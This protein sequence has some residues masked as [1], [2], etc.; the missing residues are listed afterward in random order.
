[1]DTKALELQLGNLLGNM[2]QF[3]FLRAPVFVTVTRLGELGPLLVQSVHFQ[4][5]LGNLCMLEFDHDFDF[6]YFL[7]FAFEFFDELT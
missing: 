7:F 2:R 1:M 4:L 5:L 3:V 6:G